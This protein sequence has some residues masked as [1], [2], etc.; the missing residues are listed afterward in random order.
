MQYERWIVH[1]H[2]GSSNDTDDE[3]QNKGRTRNCYFLGIWFFAAMEIFFLYQLYHFNAMHQCGNL[4]YSSNSWKEG[5]FLSR[6]QF[7]L[8]GPVH[9]VSEKNKLQ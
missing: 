5:A 7:M 2:A 1:F 8:S 6:M 3:G 9:P 4:S